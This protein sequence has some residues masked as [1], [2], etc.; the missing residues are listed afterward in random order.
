MNSAKNVP[1][2]LPLAP[3]GVHGYVRL[4]APYFDVKRFQE[5][6]LDGV[7]NCLTTVITVLINCRLSAAGLGVGCI[8]AV[9]ALSF[10]MRRR[11]TL[12]CLYPL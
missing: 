3:F 4:R 5:V 6:P 2:L 1:P 12:A 9:L 10:G 7:C 11:Y 8:G